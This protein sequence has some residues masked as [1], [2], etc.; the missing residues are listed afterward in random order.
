MQRAKARKTSKGRSRKEREPRTGAGM[1]LEDADTRIHRDLDT[2]LYEMKR[3]S[4]ESTAYYQR[5][6]DVRSAHRDVRLRHIRYAGFLRSRLDAMQEA[7]A[8]VQSAWEV[9]YGVMVK[10]DTFS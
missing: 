9:M 10:A 6:Q 7:W 8:R 3:V 5:M 2:I 1:V 4:E